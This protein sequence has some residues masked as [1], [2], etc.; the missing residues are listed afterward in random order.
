MLSNPIYIGKL[1]HKDK[2]HDGQHDGIIPAELW[3]A[4]QAK[5]RNSAAERGKRTTGSGSALLMGMIRDSAGRPMSPSFSVKGGRRY[6][7]YVSSISKDIDR[8]LAGAKAAPIARVAA[9]RLEVAVREALHA[10]LT[11]EW[12]LVDLLDDRDT[13]TTRLR[14]AMA[15]EL[16]RLLGPYATDGIRSLF[17]RLDI[18]LTV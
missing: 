3:E 5:L 17:K 8:G 11:D 2:L 18:S 12:Q 4:V 9:G 13:A 6:H 1:R 16:A 15:A 7:Y 10:L 14:L